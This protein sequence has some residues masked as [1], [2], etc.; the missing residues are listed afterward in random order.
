MLALGLPCLRGIISIHG[1]GG[2]TTR[3]HHHHRR[4][5]HAFG[6]RPQDD[7]LLYIFR[8]GSCTLGSMYKGELAPH[9]VGLDVVWGSHL[10]PLMPRGSNERLGKAP[11]RAAFLP[12][13]GVGFVRRGGSGTGEGP[14]HSLVL[15]GGVSTGSSGRCSRSNGQH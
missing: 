14:T 8:V 9:I 13:R 3:Y 7:V 10:T 6:V 1:E 15:V 5:F 11:N 2:A 4:L 12:N